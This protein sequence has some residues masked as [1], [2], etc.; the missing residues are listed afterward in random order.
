MSAP[1]QQSP[2]APQSIQ[3]EA[4]S[5]IESEFKKSYIYST[6][7]KDAIITISSVDGKVTLLGGVA[8]AN[9]KPLAGYAAEALNGV[10]LVDNRLEVQDVSGAADT[11]QWI[12]SKIRSALETHRSLDASA[13]N[14]E[15]KDGVVTLRGEA[16]SQAHKDLAT[17]FIGDIQGV[18]EVRNN[19]TVNSVVEGGNAN[20]ADKL[21]NGAQLIA[22]FIDDASITAQ[23]RMSLL[24]RR[25]TSALRT[26]VET[27]EGVVSLAG[28]AANNAELDLVTKLVSD[29]KGVKSVINNMSI[30]TTM[31]Q[32]T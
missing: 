23:V 13:T 21:E 24:V 27:K 26:K 17:E 2:P 18:L 11:D 28:V 22:E 8:R 16:E 30:E 12:S 7:L 4:D 29:I 5:L 3:S 10:K 9:L 6:H 32:K 15:I 14:I 19:M 1:A 25:S 31:S 20:V